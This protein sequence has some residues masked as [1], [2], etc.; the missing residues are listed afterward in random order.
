[1]PYYPPPPGGFARP[2]ATQQT[3]YANEQEME[4]EMEGFQA[5]HQQLQSQNRT[6]YVLPSMVSKRQPPRFTASTPVP[7]QTVQIQQLDSTQPSTFTSPSK[8]ITEGMAGL[9]TKS[10]SGQDT[11]NARRSMQIDKE[12]Q[13]PTKTLAASIPLGGSEQTGS[14]LQN[15][16]QM[17]ETITEGALPTEKET[18]RRQR[19]QPTTWKVEP[20]GQTVKDVEYVYTIADADAWSA[21]GILLHPKIGSK[22]PPTAPPLM[23]FGAKEFTPQKSKV[24]LIIISETHF[25][26]P[27]IKM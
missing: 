6:P 15:I 8:S 4:Y 7:A 20:I 9:G 16:T 10:I 21:V 23:Q 11:P 27:H 24:C 26:S 18:R 22:A 19:Q 1:M 5:V 12:S 17:V 3:Y 13:L 2:S 25:M 14:T